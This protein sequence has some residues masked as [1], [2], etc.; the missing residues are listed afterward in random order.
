MYASQRYCLVLLKERVLPLDDR[1]FLHVKINQ[2][3]A[4]QGERE[5]IECEGEPG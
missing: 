5:E 4:H 3:S 1:V 2:S